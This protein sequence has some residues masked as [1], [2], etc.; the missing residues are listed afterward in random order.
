VKVTDTAAVL[1]K[2]AI[3]DFRTVGEA[4]VMAWH[5]IIGDL[6]AADALAGVTRWYRDRADRLM[7]AHLREA[8]GLV[9][10]DRRRDARLKAEQDRAEQAPLEPV[11]RR[12]AELEAERRVELR[13]LSKGLLER[14]PLTSDVVAE[15]F[16]PGR[17]RGFQTPA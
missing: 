14:W 15:R 3:F 11:G 7:P 5:E 10:A 9:Q 16:A 8:V 4:D 13:A 12:F 2:A 17:H 1:A 6:D